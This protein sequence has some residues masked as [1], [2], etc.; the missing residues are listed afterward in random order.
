MRPASAA[1]AAAVAGSHRMVTKVDVLFNRE[2]VAEWLPVVDGTVTFDASAARLASLN[3]T[4]ADPVRLPINPGDVLGPFGAELAVSRGVMIGDTVE[5]VQLGVF[6]IQSS[7][8]DGDV[9]S[10]SI[11]AED[12]SRTVS[13]ARLEDTVQVPAGTNYA[14][15]IADL[16][17]DGMPGLEVV[18]PT[19]GH[20]T[21]LLTFDAQ[22]DRWDLAQQMATSIGHQVLFDGAGRLVLRPEASFQQAPSMTIAEGQN[23]LSVRL[24][25]DRATAYNRVIAVGRNASTG[26]TVRGVATDDDPASPTYYDGPFGRKPRFFASEFIATGQ[27]AETAAAAI[28]AG[29]LGVARTLELVAV[30]DPRI[31]CGDVIAVTR[32][33]LGI[34]ETHIVD[35]VTIGLGPESAVEIRTRSNQL[36]VLS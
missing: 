14:D 12:R 34:N 31:E 36:A 24:R 25:L 33:A 32:Q 35:G 20:T 4:V 8:I 7:D 5:L 3:V 27:Q 17:T 18:F 21:P 22:S 2:V 1:F 28:L 23:M 11:T 6:P 15:A 16:V 13:D 26:A 9:L 19:V 29:Q 30:P 10:T